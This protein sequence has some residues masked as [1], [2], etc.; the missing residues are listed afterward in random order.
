MVCCDLNRHISFFV[1][2]VAV[3]LCE[4]LFSL[5]DVLFRNYEHVGFN[6]RIHLI[7]VVSIGVSFLMTS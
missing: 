6:Q 5:L 4:D 1:S 7:I 3:V 2:I